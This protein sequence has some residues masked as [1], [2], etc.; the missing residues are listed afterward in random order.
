MAWNYVSY[1]YFFGVIE[2]FKSLSISL[3]YWQDLGFDNIGRRKIE[4]SY[5]DSFLILPSINFHR[6]LNFKAYIAIILVLYGITLFVPFLS[7]VP[8][9][10]IS[11]LLKKLNFRELIFQLLSLHLF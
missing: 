10:L 6:F 9:S 5:R 8:D 3:F 1:N 7:V 2:L 11:F 4:H